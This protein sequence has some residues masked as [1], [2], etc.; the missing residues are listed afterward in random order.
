MLPPVELNAERVGLGIDVGGTGVKAGIVDLGTGELV[1]RRVR[2][3]T[4]QPSTPEAVIETIRQVV[5][6]VTADQ[7]LGPG[8]PVGCGMPCVVKGGV[9]LTAANID[10]AWIGFGA[11]QG[12]SAALGRRVLA[13]NDADAAAIAE[14][15]VGA[16]RDVPGTVLVL[17]IGTGIGSGLLLDGKLVPNT[18]L[19]HLEFKGKD[20]ETLLSGVAR[21]RRKLR[22]KAW[23]QEFNV[24]LAR[25]EL[26]LSPDLFILGGGVSKVFDKYR[27]YLV[28]SVPIITA[29]FLN[30]SGIAG[31]ALAAAERA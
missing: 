21:E 12:I 10:K 15:R 14:A 18:E 23:A 2:L 8:T 6:T 4:P 22:W 11:A 1:T 26:Y 30:T 3:N 13:I 28:A 19:G 16:A 20:A 27:E 25:V 9:T 31:A 5:E 7:P 17:T 24:Y 29:K